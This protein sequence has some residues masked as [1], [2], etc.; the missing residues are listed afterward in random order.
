M[1]KYKK[2]L[3]DAFIIVSTYY[4]KICCFLAHCFL[5]N[6]NN[7]ISG[8]NTFNNQHIT[9]CRKE[10]LATTKENQTTLKEKR[11]IIRNT[12]NNLAYIGS[13]CQ[14]LGIRMIQHR[15][16]MRK[17][18]HYK[19]YQAI[20]EFGRHAFYIE[21]LEDY[22]CQK[23]EELLKREG[24][25]IREHQRELNTIVSVRTK[26]EYRQDKFQQIQN[27]QKE[28]YERNRSKLIKY[29]KDY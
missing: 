8:I 5:K 29:Q 6:W 27:K 24:K 15:V 10:I 18:Q 25:K 17:H 14:A 13:T 7:S 9:K 23:R 22:P 1:R 19:L 11:N 26:Q 2:D 3:T 4:A 20:N 16:D 12:Q 21:L 28:I